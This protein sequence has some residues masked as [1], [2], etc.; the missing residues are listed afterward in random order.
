MILPDGKELNRE[1]VQAGLAWWYRKYSDDKSLGKL[2]AD[3]KKNRRGLWSDKNPVAPW[4][5]RAA[6]R[7]KSDVPLSNIKVVP[8][9]M[10]AGRE[11]VTGTVF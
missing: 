4:D 11:Q 6:Q 7:A 3:A 5:W 10:D 1:L 9:G 2:E 8:K